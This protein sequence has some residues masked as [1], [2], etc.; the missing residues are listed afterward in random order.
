VT[1]SRRIV[2]IHYI[3][4]NETLLRLYPIDFLIGKGFRV[5]HWN[6]APLFGYAAN[7]YEI[8][9]PCSRPFESWAAL[10][11]EL[12][13]P[14]TDETFF[15]VGMA[16]A[17]ETA[18]VWRALSRTRARL[19]TVLV[20][21]APEPG[22]SPLRRLRDN[23]VFIRSPRKLAGF[24]LKRAALGLKKLGWARD[25]DVTFAAGDAAR[26]AAGRARVVPIHHC[27][28][29][30]WLL[31]RAEEPRLVAGRTA[32]YLDEFMPFH[33]DLG[34]LGIRR[35]IDPARYYSTLNAFFGRLE[36]RHGVE[37]VVAAHP[38]SSYPANP[39]GGRKIFR[40]ATRLLVR[41]CEFAVTT[42]S[43]SLGYAVLARRPLVFF[44][45]DEIAARYR[46]LRL[47]LYP[48]TYARALGRRLAN[49]DRPAAE[50]LEIPPIDGRLYDDYRHRYIVSREAEGR[51]SR[52][53][54]L[55]FLSRERA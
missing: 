1:G 49:L 54:W 21:L 10:D 45:S 40:G 51:V 41:D 2:F 43:N 29:D 17:P 25:P 8:E 36:E 42:F 19:A 20:G 24:V 7:A 46:S 22:G 6:L 35:R 11:E 31:A 55:E 14:E 30:D 52:E 26:E 48:A 12:R 3:A 44:T 34:I 9:H 37:I 23:A 4:L 13:R 28:Y 47:D 33:A 27:D 32:V 18:R 15:V 39:F 16:Y 53:L 38:K 50:D 5:E